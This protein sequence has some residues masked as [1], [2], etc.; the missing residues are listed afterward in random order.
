MICAVVLNWNAADETIA[1]LE[2]LREM[3]DSRLSTIVVCDN[4]S[5]DHSIA[6]IQSWGRQTLRYPVRCIRSSDIGVNMARYREPVVVIDNQANIGYAAGCNSGIRYALSKGCESIWILN[7]DTRFHPDAVT[8]LIDFSRMHPE[9]GVIG[10]TLVDFDCRDCVQCTGGCYYQPLTT[11]FRYAGKGLGLIEAVSRP[12]EKE[13]DYVYGASMFIRSE[14]FRRIGLFNEEYF[15]FY[16]ELDFCHRAQAAGYRLGWSP[17]SIVYHRQSSS[18]DNLGTEKQ[19]EQ[20]ANYHENLSTL[21]FTARFYP[22]LFYAAA[23]FRFVG[24]FLKM[25]IYRK[26]YLLHPLCRSYADFFIERKNR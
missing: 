16:E 10:S 14:V 9:V 13:L 1:C 26:W 4:G 17:D 24:K 21:I 12:L 3:K 22:H 15:L 8:A 23:P 6:R 19:R 11:I 7:N 2:S 25:V 20:I 5:T 18:F